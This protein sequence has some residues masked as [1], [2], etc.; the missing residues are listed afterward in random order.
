MSRRVGQDYPFAI[1]ACRDGWV[2]VNV[3]TPAHWEALCAFMKQPELLDDPRFAVQLAAR[4]TDQAGAG[5][6]VCTNVVREL[7]A[8]KGYLFSE[9]EPASLKGV[10]EPVRLCT[11]GVGD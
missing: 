10:E 3:L 11:L 9:R 6:I 4:V 1:V 2:A 7:V 5:E 8:G